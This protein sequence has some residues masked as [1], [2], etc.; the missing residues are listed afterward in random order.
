VI[1]LANPNFLII[2]STMSF[3][4]SSTLLPILAAAVALS[5]CGED[6]SL[7]QKREEQIVEIA[8]LRGELK[9]IEEKLA[10]MPP[11]RSEELAEASKNTAEQTAEAERL[12]EEIG[13]LNARRRA[14]ESEFD[15][16]RR[17]YAVK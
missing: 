12:E 1:R 2:I 11:D 4:R 14:I 16:Y 15:R 17:T 5:S 3:F 10:S 7:V 6:E 9:L 8:K 13:E